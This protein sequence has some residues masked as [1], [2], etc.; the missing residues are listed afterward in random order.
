[1]QTILLVEQKHL[2][3]PDTLKELY[4]YGEGGLTIKDSEGNVTHEVKGKS[5]VIEGEPEEFEA[6]LENHDDIWTTLDPGK[7]DWFLLKVN[8]EA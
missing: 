2:P 5:L 4:S 1:M 6:W 8:K 3:I 7:G